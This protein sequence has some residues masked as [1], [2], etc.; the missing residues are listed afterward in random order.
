MIPGIAA[1]HMNT[2]RP[3]HDTMGITA[4]PAALV[5]SEVQMLPCRFSEVYAPERAFTKRTEEET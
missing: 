1:S 3:L 2:V 4:F 5:I